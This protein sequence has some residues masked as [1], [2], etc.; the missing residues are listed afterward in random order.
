MD[1]FIVIFS[2]E[3][4]WIGMSHAMHIFYFFVQGYRYAYTNLILN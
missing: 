2:N 1:M 3:S 4:D